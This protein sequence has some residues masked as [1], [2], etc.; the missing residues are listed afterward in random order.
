MTN[1]G[2]IKNRHAGLTIQIKGNVINNGEYSG[3]L[4]FIGDDTQTMSGTQKYSCGWIEKLPDGKINAASDLVI[5]STTTVYLNND[6]L[7]MGNY[8]LKKNSKRDFVN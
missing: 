3:Y 7:N 8:K 2:I 5:D 1:N 4:R 6:I